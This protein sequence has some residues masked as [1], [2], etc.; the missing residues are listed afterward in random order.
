MG[1]TLQAIIGAD[2]G[3]WNATLLNR[4][5]AIVYTGSETFVATF[6]RG[7]EEASLFTPAVAWV[8]PSLGIIKLSLSAS[9]TAALDPGVY[10]LQIFVVSGGLKVPGF[11]GRVELLPTVGTVAPGLTWCSEADMLLRSDVIRSLQG[12]RGANDATGLLLQRV[13]A[14]AERSRHLVTRYDPQAGFIKVRQN[15]LDPFVQS[16]DVPS[17]LAVPLSKQDLTTA[18]ATVGG[19]V[20]EAALR[21]IIARDAISL[22]LRRQATSGNARSYL[23]EAEAQS[24][25]AD[26]RFKCYRAQIVTASP[27]VSP[28]P[29][30]PISNFLV[31]THEC[32][33]LPAGTAP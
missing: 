1:Q 12:G 13:E 24:A 32:I 29:I 6:S 17:P 21:D 4:G 18:L 31:G 5:S 22:L 19:I 11:D 3:P 33:L 30:G 25:M 14:T 2:N 26:E 10:V 16:M 20:L 15:V 27:I 8:T 7:G 28:S 9:Q 23:E